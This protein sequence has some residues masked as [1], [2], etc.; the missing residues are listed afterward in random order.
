MVTKSNFG[1]AQRYVYDLATSLPR[2]DFDVTVAAGGNGILFEK[3][4]AKNIRTI[5]IPHL[6]RDIFFWKDIK[7][8]FNMFSLLKKERP[9]IVHVNSSKMGGLGALAARVLRIKKVIFTVHGFAFN[10][11]RNFF[12]RLVLKAISFI[13]V[14]LSTNV[15]YVSKV[16]MDQTPRWLL[17]GRAAHIPLGIISLPLLEKAAAR[18][19]LFLKAGIPD[20]GQELLFSIGELTKN[21]GYEYALEALQKYTSDYSYIVAGTGELK[22]K[23]EERIKATNL[24]SNISLL[25]FVPDAAQYLKAAD[26]FLLPSIKEGLP[27]VLIEAGFAEVPVIST[28]VGGIKDFAGKDVS[29]L[30]HPKNPSAILEALNQRTVFYPQKLHLETM[31]AK[32]ISI[33]N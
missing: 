6:E 26:V 21:K 4:A 14:F 32:T 7:S 23:L 8:F 10:E 1:G 12:S 20:R 30:I 5:T 18:A 17:R 24:D 28:N 22:G 31:V 2:D 19:Q 25:G 11:D 16:D 13:T 27:Y 9:D 15:I 33:Y 29:K 3:C